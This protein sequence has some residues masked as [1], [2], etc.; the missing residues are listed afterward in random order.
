MLRKFSHAFGNLSISNKFLA[1]LSLVLIFGL[2]S[3]AANLYITDYEKDL[4]DDFEESRQEIQL[5]YSLGVTVQRAR[6]TETQAEILYLTLGTEESVPY[7]TDVIAIMEDAEEILEELKSSQGQDEAERETL[8]NIAETISVY[9]TTVNLLYKDYIL[10]RGGEDTG[11]GGD[12]IDTLDAIGTYGVVDITD[13]RVLLITYLKH[14]SPDALMR[15]PKQFTALQTA[16]EEA[17]LPDAERDELLALVDKAR[18]Q[19]V[20]LING[21]TDIA[22]AFFTLSDTSAVVDTLVT[23]FIQ[24]E[25]EQQAEARELANDAADL[26]NTL[27]PITTAASLF[28]GL[29]AVYLLSQS[30][31]RQINNLADASRQIAGGDYS[32]RVKVSTTDE[33]G[34]LGTSFNEMVDK[35]E[36]REAELRQQAVELRIATAKARE[37]TRLKSEFLANVSHELRTPLNAIIGFSDML[38]MGMSGEL[39]EKQSHKVNRLRENGTRL[40]DL[41]NDV[42]DLARIE[43]KRVEITHKPFSPRELAAHLTAQ[44]EVLAQEKRLDFETIIDPSLPQTIMGDAKRIEQV[45]VNLLSN[46]VKFTETGSVS[47]KLNGNGSQDTWCICVQDTG[48]GIPP[49]AH[50]LIFEKFRQ[51]D[52]SSSRTYTGSGLGLAISRELVQAMGG[53]IQLE[54]Q[55]DAGST[56]TVILPLHTQPALLQ[57]QLEQVRN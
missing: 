21:D 25:S 51:V 28:F 35:I 37:A 13:M 30:I 49:H 50:D 45:I 14:F 56:F 32:Q 31:A 54:S 8:D 57:S 23:E 41:V 44:M 15:L 4:R 22:E 24:N 47:L 43:A 2:V 55:V 52:G 53:H 40:L 48:I 46:A 33:I 3:I 9:K 16:I 7:V 5:A 11:F 6:Y 26:R 36:A 18:T 12:L 10:V 1:A 19:F 27:T 42:L 39:N 34:Q 17:D 29:L 38:L 20:N